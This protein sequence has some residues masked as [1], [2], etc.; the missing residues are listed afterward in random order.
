MPPA[1]A[2]TA[3]ATSCTI[4]GSYVSNASYAE[5]L[6]NECVQRVCHY[7]CADPAGACTQQC[8]SHCWSE[9]GSAPCLHDCASSHSVGLAVAVAIPFVGRL[10]V[11][12]L[13]GK[14][15]EKLGPCLARRFECCKP[16]GGPD[17]AALLDGF[18]AGVAADAAAEPPARFTM[19]ELTDEDSSWADAVELQGLSPFGAVAE[20]LGKLLF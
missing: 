2:T 3:A 17:G 14:V 18:F 19:R 13:K 1:C 8:V 7:D 5:A 16:R 11:D 4:I 10:G 15:M 20:G 6:C 12:F 9:L